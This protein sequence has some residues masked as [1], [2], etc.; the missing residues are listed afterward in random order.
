MRLNFQ[1]IPLMAVRL[2]A[3]QLTLKVSENLLTG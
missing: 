3:E 1:R 2:N